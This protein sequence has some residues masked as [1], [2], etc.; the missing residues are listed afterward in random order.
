MPTGWHSTTELYPSKR[1]QD[2]NNTD[3]NRLAFYHWATSPIETIRCQL[4]LLLLMLMSTGWH[5]TTELYPSQT[6][7]CPTWW[8][9]QL[10][11]MKWQVRRNA[12]NKPRSQQAKQEPRTLTWNVFG[13]AELLQFSV[14]HLRPLLALQDL[15]LQ[16]L[17]INN[18]TVTVSMWSAVVV[19]N[20]FYFSL[21]F[22]TILLFRLGLLG[23][24]LTLFILFQSQFQY[25]LTL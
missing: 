3:V 5:S 16:Q 12:A 13:L 18:V 10:L 20:P 14:H 4:L 1:Q 24:F 15:V 8:Y 23:L 6:I 17:L 25:N 21:S 22:S 2:A 9:Q 11:I 19:F 7:G